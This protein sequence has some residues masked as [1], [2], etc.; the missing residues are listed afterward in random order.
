MGSNLDLL[1]FHSEA[2]MSRKVAVTTY[3][4]MAHS[5]FL[6]KSVLKVSN[7]DSLSAFLGIILLRMAHLYVWAF[8]TSNV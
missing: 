6:I 8:I 5:P 2:T 7:L 1:P 3:L 4:R